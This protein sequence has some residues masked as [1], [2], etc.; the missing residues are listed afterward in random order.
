MKKLFLSFAFAA[1]VATAYGQQPQNVPQATFT[2]GS[3]PAVTVSQAPYLKYQILF[4]GGHDSVEVLNNE[5]NPGGKALAK[6]WHDFIGFTKDNT[7]DLRI[8]G[9]C[10]S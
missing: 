4:I 1:V 8:W 6:Q 9:C 10:L 3:Q 7:P 2:P 5:G